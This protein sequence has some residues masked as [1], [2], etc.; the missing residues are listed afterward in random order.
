MDFI[1]YFL[2]TYNIIHL[3]LLLQK[4]VLIRFTLIQLCHFL[5]NFHIQLYR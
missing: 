2:F 1:D 3:F 4:I 5:L